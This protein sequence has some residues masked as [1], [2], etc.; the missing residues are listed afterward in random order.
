[1][2]QQLMLFFLLSTSTLN[3]NFSVH[4]FNQWFVINFSIMFFYFLMK[5]HN[6]KNLNY[7]TCLFITA[8]IPPTIYLASFVT[9]LFMI[10]T[11]LV[12]TFRNR[13][14]ILKNLKSLKLQF[15]FSNIFLLSSNYF[16]LDTLYVI[17]R[18]W[19]I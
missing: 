18:F 11:V 9:S 8:V 4:F 16:Y 5:F 6:S 19:P 17:G 13:N 14:I 2:I 15:F 1:M 12:L 10:L 7:L 3:S